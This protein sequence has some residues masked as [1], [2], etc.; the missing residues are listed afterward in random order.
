MQAELL[1]QLI[2]VFTD[3]WS[4]TWNFDLLDW[5]AVLKTNM[6]FSSSNVDMMLDQND[7][8]ETQ[9]LKNSIVNHVKYGSTNQKSNTTK[10][11]YLTHYVDTNDTL[12]GL[13]LKYGC[14]V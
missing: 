2:V 10:L 14:K 9:F 8:S 13:A 5:S 6:S 4:S 3:E 1:A 12:Q 7:I 11:K